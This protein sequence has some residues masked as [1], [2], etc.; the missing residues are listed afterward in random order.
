MCETAGGAQS[1]LCIIT[2]IIAYVAIGIN[3]NQELCNDFMTAAE[4]TATWGGMKT[5]HGNV[6]H[7]HGDLEGHNISLTNHNTALGAHDSSIGGDLMSHDMNIDA[8]LIVHGSSM[9]IEHNRLR[10]GLTQHHIDIRGVLNQLLQGG[11]GSTEAKL[12]VVLAVQREIIRLLLTHDDDLA[13][14]AFL[15]SCDGDTMSCPDPL[16]CTDPE[17]I[18]GELDDD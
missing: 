8:D 6:Q 4:V 2:D 12:D 9:T 5:V 15:L 17:C 14:T 11:S 10:D 13:T 3:E 1:A 18:F 16:P 7:V